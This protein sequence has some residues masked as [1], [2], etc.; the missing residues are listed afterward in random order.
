MNVKAHIE[1][2]EPTSGTYTSLIKFI[3]AVI[4]AKWKMRSKKHSICIY[5]F[6]TSMMEVSD[7]EVHDTDS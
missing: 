4:R 3:W 6:M 1:F 2:R 7:Q 5:A